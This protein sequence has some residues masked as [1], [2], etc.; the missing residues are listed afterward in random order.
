MIKGMIVPKNFEECVQKNIKDAH[1][2]VA[3]KMIYSTCRKQFPE[4]NP[5]DQFD[6]TQNKQKTNYV[7]EEE[8]HKAK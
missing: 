5:F 4:R 2:D 6:S 3:A 1:S 8:F 7:S